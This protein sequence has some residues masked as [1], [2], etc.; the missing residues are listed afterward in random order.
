MGTI[1]EEELDKSI[2]EYKWKIK[3]LKT[4]N[5][6]IMVGVAPSDFYINSTEHY[7]KCGWYFYCCDST[8]YSGPPFKYSG[9]NSNLSKVNDEI[10]LVMNMKKKNIKI[11]N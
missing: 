5:K 8:L 2:E 6:E 3:I 9:S 4:Q 10:I 11:Y 7:N 1:C